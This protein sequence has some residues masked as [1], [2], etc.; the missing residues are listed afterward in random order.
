MRLHWGKTVMMELRSGDVMDY[1]WYEMAKGW[2]IEEKEWNGLQRFV[3]KRS[4]EVALAFLEAK[5]PEA[6][7]TGALVAGQM[8]LREAAAKLR[9]LL[10]D[11]ASFS[12]GS[13]EGALK[14]VYFVR[15]AAKKALEAMG[16]S[17]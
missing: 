9:A 15:E 2:A 12:Q 1:R 8:R 11:P 6:R 4:A 14:T 7:K 5:E 10:D 13:G 16:V 3:K 17:E